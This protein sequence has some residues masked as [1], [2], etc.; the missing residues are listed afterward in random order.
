MTVT[1]Q[2]ELKLLQEMDINNRNATKTDLSLLLECV[3]FQMNCPDLQKQAL[4]TINSICEKREDNVDLLREIGGVAFLYNLS[5]SDIIHSDVR[6]MALFTLGTLA[7]A[8]VYCKN[9]LCRKETFMDLCGYM[10]EE[11]TSLKQKSVSIY[12]LSVLVASNKAGQTIAQTT[13]CIEILLDLFSLYLCSSTF[14][15]S[16]EDSLRDV[17]TAH[18]LSLWVSV[19]SALC[20]CVNNPQNDVAQ[21][22]CLSSF[23]EIKKWLHQISLPCAEVFHHLCSFI[24]MTVA[25]NEYVQDHFAGSGLLETL[26][27]VLI[28]LA[29]ESETSSLSF[30]LSVT[31]TK[32]LSAC[33]ADNSTLVSGLARY[34]VVCHL[35]PL[36]AIPNLD[37]E[38]RLTVLVM[39]GHCTEASEEHQCQLVQCGGL[40]LIITLLAEDT[41]E[42]VRKAATFIL[43]TCKQ[44]IMSLG[45]P[46]GTLKQ[47]QDEQVVTE[48]EFGH[49]STPPPSR[50]QHEDHFTP[51]P[52]TFGVFKMLNAMNVMEEEGGIQTK[53]VRFCERT[54]KEKAETSQGKVQCSVCK[55]TGS[56]MPSRGRPLE[57]GR[58]VDAANSHPLK[59][60]EPQEQ[61][62]AGTVKCKLQASNML[63]KEIPEEEQSRFNERCAG[64][65]LS[66]ERVTSRTFASLL[67]SC[68]Q[69]CDMHRALLE[70][71]ERFRAHHHSSLSGRQRNRD[72]IVE[73]TDSKPESV[74]LESHA[75][76]RPGKISC[77]NFPEN[78][79]LTPTY[80]GAKYS[81]PRY[82]WNRHNGITLTPMRRTLSRTDK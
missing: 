6:V 30:R 49:L 44:A 37:C 58:D 82:G 54:P 22:I 40:P 15:V 81:L 21:R 4:I 75:N 13:G 50:L 16:N 57:G 19:S 48:E 59:P 38:D 17:N 27:Y 65:V 18:D 41:S 76:W 78:V 80:R 20:G 69:S 53:S 42:E 39:L 46:S 8:N 7:E 43:Q 28:Y 31:I 12:L 11:S 1:C 5:K 2:W 32:T 14:P 56:L 63:R 3:K 34:G 24:A 45:V 52:P 10:M 33:V 67:S 74:A 66:F 62:V 79:S 71:T 70:A 64:C 47:Q 77:L 9:F 36:L 29:S 73:P 60:A 72:D 51:L 55:G 61:N 23:P 68:H 25:N 35:F 26:I